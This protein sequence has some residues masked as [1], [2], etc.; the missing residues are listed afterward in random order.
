MTYCL[1]GVQK[2]PSSPTKNKNEDNIY[3]DTW[4]SFLIFVIDPSGDEVGAAVLGDEVGA[5]VPGDKV[6]A[7]VLGVVVVVVVVVVVAQYFQEIS[8]VCAGAGLQGAQHGEP[9]AGC[10]RGNPERSVSRQ[11]LEV[12]KTRPSF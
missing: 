6:G 8:R 9:Y 1:T 10:P 3:V 11:S 12:G 2:T 4:P 7:V 5:A